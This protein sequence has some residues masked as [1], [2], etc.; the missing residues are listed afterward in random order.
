MAAKRTHAELARAAAAWPPAPCP[1]SA[2]ALWA[3]AEEVPFGETL[4]FGEVF[5][6][7]AAVSRAMQGLG[8]VGR[9]LDRSYDPSPQDGYNVLNPGGFLLLLSTALDIAPGGV[10]W[11]APPCSTWIW[12]SRNS[13]G[14]NLAPQ[15][16]VLSR[17]VVA[18]N[19]LV[20][21]LVL[22]LEI[23]TLRRVHWIIE[24]PANSVMWQYPAMEQLL[25][26]HGVLPVHLE[27]G[28]YGALSRKPTDLM[29]T[30]PYLRVLARTCDRELR[31][32]LAESGLETTTKWVDGE[33]KKRCQGTKDLKGTQTYPEGF[34]AA[35]ALAFKGYFGPPC[36][37]EPG[38]ASSSSTSAASA[39]RPADRR[40]Q[41]RELIPQLPQPVQ[42]GLH[43]AWWLRDFLGEPW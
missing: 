32:A 21:R 38:A 39:P 40:A 30:A 11:A 5:A 25:H 34:G 35:H 22:V 42:E 17:S 2:A 41:L 23:L 15:G 16:N 29:G 43:E 36:G 1:G 13:T 26:R 7:H 20:E 6:G 9:S 10:L 33:G 37:G 24:Q 31:Q 27:M 3:M 28:A 18:Q 19:A 14:R 4:H 12:L 8:Y